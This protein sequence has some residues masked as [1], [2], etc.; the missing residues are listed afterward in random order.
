MNYVEFLSKEVRETKGRDFKFVS[1]H[2]CTF[3]TNIAAFK[4][5]MDRLS[6]GLRF[7]AK[8]H[9]YNNEIIFYAMFIREKHV[10]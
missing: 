8:K 4:R 6:N 7:M 2:K 10:S 3:L 9:C 1:S 5:A